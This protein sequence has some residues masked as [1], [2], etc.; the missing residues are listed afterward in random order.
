MALKIRNKDVDELAETLARITGETKTTAVKLA[1]RER[2]ARVQ[3]AGSR[4]SLADELTQIGRH[5]AA[6]SKLDQRTD[7]QI[8]GYDKDGVP[9]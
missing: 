1:L 2:L 3:Q 7:D 4:G 9:G 6:L 5:C 8:L